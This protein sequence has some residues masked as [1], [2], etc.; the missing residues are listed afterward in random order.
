MDENTQQTSTTTIEETRFDCEK[1]CPCEIPSAILC[2]ED[3]VIDE[4]ED[5][6]IKRITTAS[7]SLAIL[8]I[9][10]TVAFAF[11]FAVYRSLSTK[12]GVLFAFLSVLCITAAL[13][14]WVFSYQFKSTYSRASFIVIM[15]NFALW[16]VINFFIAKHS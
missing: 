13:V 16:V 15:S 6:K 9:G 8:A 5:K 10:F 1:E 3:T 14:L 7:F 11:S 4:E 12:S 2:E